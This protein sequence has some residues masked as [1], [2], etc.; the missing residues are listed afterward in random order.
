MK[1]FLEN[2]GTIGQPLVACALVLGSLTSS[3]H[4]QDQLDGATVE[5]MK[6]CVS[7]KGRGATGIVKLVIALRA[8]LPKVPAA[9][10]TLYA[11]ALP[12][13]P[14]KAEAVAGSPFYFVWSMGQHLDR[15]IDKLGHMPDSS[16]WSLRAADAILRT[17][18]ALNELTYA[19]SALTAQATRH[20][21]VADRSRRWC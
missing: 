4:A 17:S 5:T 11:Q 2:L 12:D 3:A 13:D 6:I 20:A 7:L 8:H 9:D 10:A 15:L 16:D 14:R 18:A 19:M 1:R 21:H